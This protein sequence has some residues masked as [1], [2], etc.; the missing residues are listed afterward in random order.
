MGRVGA[1]NYLSNWV[2]ISLVGGI[3]R[4]GFQLQS[5]VPL[6]SLLSSHT[7]QTSYEE[8]ISLHVV[9]KL[10]S[11]LGFYPVAALLTPAGH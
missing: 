1:K 10:V 11:S 8:G 4:V 5:L 3:D 9:V 2:C 6:S 7:H